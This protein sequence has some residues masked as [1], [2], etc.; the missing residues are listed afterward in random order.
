MKRIAQSRS[1]RVLPLLLISAAVL[2]RTA[3]APPRGQS[4]GQSPAIKLGEVPKELAPVDFLAAPPTIDGVLDPGLGRLAHRTFSQVDPFG[5]DA[6]PV[7]AHYRLAYGTDFLYVYVEARGDKLT[8]NDR[9][10]QNGDGFHMVI[11][12]P[13]PGD[14]PTDEFYVA[15][16][17]A[18]DR[19]ELE[20]SRR[21]F[22]YYN[23][24]KIFVPMSRGAKLETAAH[25]GV[26]SFEFLLPWQDLHPYHPWL[27][28]G[29]GFNLGFVKASGQ[30]AFY[31]RVLP[32]DLGQENSTRRYLRLRFAEPVLEKGTQTFVELERN[33]L[34]PGEPLLARSVTLSAGEG[35]ESLSATVLSGEGV[36]LESTTA[37][38]ACRRGLTR[39]EFGVKLGELP[40]G[41]YRVAWSSRRGYSRGDDS[42]RAAG[43]T[44]LPLADAVTLED[45]LD[46][47]KAHLSPGSAA[48]LRSLL[49]E[50]FA[51]LAFIRPYENAAKERLAL[52]RLEDDLA[53]AESG[54]DMYAERTGYFRR[55]FLSKVDGTL[56]PYAVRIPAG[57]DPRAAKKYPLIVYLHGSASDE[58]NLTGVDYLS[59]G[60]AIEL[61]PRG[62]GPS[63]AYTRDH[64]QEDIEEAIA[65]VV[66]SYPIDEKRIILTGFS[67][68]GYGVYR[69]FFEHPERYKA[70]AVFSGN[71]SIGNEYFPGE[72]HPD[73]LADRNLAKFKGMSLFIFHGREDRNCP[74]AVT[75][76][77]AKKLGRIGADVEL[78]TEE[79]AG[80]QR[81]GPEALRRYHEWLAK[82]VR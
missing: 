27:S 62:R 82:V 23:V 69:T 22:W 47:A 30:A 6:K 68:G 50:T 32:E 26:V 44:V 48:T 20:W 35:T 12:R 52:V 67:M 59:E 21:V 57:Y 4:A 11:A 29:I 75:Q 74:F 64:A 60:D 37:E 36:R 51:S 33:H 70:L 76:E 25:D 77:L 79:G 80:H 55:A 42:S 10:Y 38:Y 14:A 1:W 15:A 65:A 46:R 24:D 53:Q 54:R 5:T 66:Q 3:S 72:G 63:N 7:E 58:T 61:A 16:C 49:A 40:S 34:R 2:V 73:F 17:S 13:L 56:Q 31:Y 78:V 81:P 43:L 45:R 19:P 8:F 71:P 28:E 41:G 18:V 39:H 9:A